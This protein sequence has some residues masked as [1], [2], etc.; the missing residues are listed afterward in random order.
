MK[1]IQERQQKVI[2]DRKIEEKNLKDL[3]KFTS[4]KSGELKIDE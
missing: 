2:E 1:I 4:N 3:A